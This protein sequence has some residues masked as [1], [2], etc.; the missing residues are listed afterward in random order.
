MHTDNVAKI[1]Q[2]VTR[3][4][5]KLLRTFDAQT[6]RDG[7]LMLIHE[8]FDV[9]ITPHGKIYCMFNET[10]LRQAQVKYRKFSKNTLFNSSKYAE[11]MKYRAVQAC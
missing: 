2:L 9:L 10:I 4:L 11:V 8:I 1:T 7:R 6:T 5:V 3:R